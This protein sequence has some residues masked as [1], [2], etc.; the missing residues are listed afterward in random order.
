MLRF[1]P[2]AQWAW[3]ADQWSVSGAMSYDLDRLV[4]EGR[5]QCERRHRN[6]DRITWLIMRFGVASA[7]KPGGDGQF[8]KR[9]LCRYNGG[10]GQLG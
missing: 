8:D 2:V 6:S 3:N 7:P 10:P 4:E 5:L 1:T 9:Q